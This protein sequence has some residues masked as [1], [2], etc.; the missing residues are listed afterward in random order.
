MGPEFAANAATLVSSLVAYEREILPVL[1]DELDRWRN[2]AQTIPD[3]LLRAA[4]LSA[5]QAKGRNPEAT[6]VFAILAPRERRAEALR[7]MAPLQIAIDYL[8]SIGEEQ[9]GD[10]LADGLA[11][12]AAIVDAVSPGTRSGDYYVHHPQ[13]E[14]GGYL[15]ALVAA[16]QNAVAQLPASEPLLPLLRR[17]ANRCGEG[18]SHTHAAARA[19]ADELE[20]WASRQEAAPGYLW[21]ELAAGASSSVATHA[22]IAAAAD[23]RTTADEAALIDAAYFPPIGALTVLLDD[24]VDRDEDREAGQHNYLGYFADNEQAATRIGLLA[25]RARAAIADLRHARRHRAIL[26]GVA[27]FYLSS[28]GA[29]S[30][31]ARP[32]RGRLLESLDPTVRLIMVAMRLRRHG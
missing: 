25:D 9:V 21:W 11:L 22:L 16:C 32:I 13:R 19:G 26:A 4:A 27:G 6:A 12:H 15:N 5:L 28:P 7:A 24:L 20:A 10:P 17:T 18:Q 29:D 31:Y 1:R 23:P 14:D 2:R 30:G 3:P 8:D